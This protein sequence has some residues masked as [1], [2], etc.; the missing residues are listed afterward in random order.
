M[1]D[2]DI[3]TAGIPLKDGCPVLRRLKAFMSQEG[4][5]A[6]LEH[7]FRDN[8][9]N[10]IDLTTA[11]TD[12]PISESA[13]GAVS[14][15][16]EPAEATV[17]AKFREYTGLLCQPRDTLVVEGTIVDPANGVIRARI[18][19]AVY[20]Q[21]GLYTVGF[22]YVRDSQLKFV[23]QT[24][25]SVERSLF[26]Y[27]TPAGPHTSGCPTINEVR[28]HLADSDPA[29]NSLLDAVEFDDEQILLALVKPIEQFNEYP[30]TLTVQYNT[31]NFP[32]RSNWLDATCGYLY[33]FAAAFYRRNRLQITGGGK[34]L[35]DR[36]KEPEYLRIAQQHLATWK[37]FMLA[38]KI[39]LNARECV[40]SVGSLYGTM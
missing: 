22:G 25:L 14:E 38:K 19:E 36:N 31:T 33:Q 16:N 6:T 9:G 17:I 30:P 32:W 35:D 5:V 28:M 40:G 8:Q 27:G 12:N 15:S 24:I 23:Q 10:P 4:V 26:G 29:E 13:E 3:I 1:P 39:F 11:F 37:D 18:P 21:S 34:T 7:I 20:A 2:L